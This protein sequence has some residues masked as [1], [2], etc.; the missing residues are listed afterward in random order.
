MAAPPTAAVARRRRMNKGIC[1]LFLLDLLAA[2]SPVTQVAN[3]YSVVSV[4]DFNHDSHRHVT[5]TFQ[6]PSGEGLQVNGL[7]AAS[8]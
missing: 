8:E 5:E 2:A 6:L 4:T 3:Y 1:S 7:P